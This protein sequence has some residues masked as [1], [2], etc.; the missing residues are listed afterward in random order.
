MG[1]GPQHGRAAADWA[2]C[3]AGCCCSRLVPV[4]GPRRWSGSSSSSRATASTC[5]FGFGAG[6]DRARGAV[7]SR[8]GHRSSASAR[9]VGRRRAH[10]GSPAH[11]GAASHG[12][13]PRALAGRLSK[14]RRAA[15][16]RRSHRA[17]GA[18]SARP[19]PAPRRLA[20]PPPALRARPSLR[21]AADVGS[22]IRRSPARSDRRR[23][24]VAGPLLRR[25]AAAR[26]RGR[27][28][29][30]FDR[31]RR[32]VHQ[33]CDRSVPRRRRA[34]PRGASAAADVGRRN[35]R[36]PMPAASAARR[37]CRRRRTR[38]AAA[39]RRPVTRG[40]PPAPA[41]PHPRRE[42]GRRGTRSPDGRRRRR[43]RDVRPGVGDRRRPGCRDPALRAR[44]GVRAARQAARSPRTPL[45]ADDHRPP[46]TR[47][48]WSLVPPARARRSR[49]ARDVVILGRRPVADP[50]VPRRAARLDRGRHGLQDPRATRAARRPLVHHRPRLHE[51]RAVR[52]ADGH[53]GRGR[54]P[55]S[56]SRRRAVPP[57]RRRGAAP[58]ER[59]DVT[60]L[61]RATLPTRAA[62]S[63]TRPEPTAMSTPRGSAR[64]AD[65]RSRRPMADDPH[66]STVVIR[67]A[68]IDDGGSTI[69]PAATAPR[70]RRHPARVRPAAATASHG[71]RS[72]RR[73][74][75]TPRRGA[76]DLRARARARP[77]VAVRGRAARPAP[78]PRQAP[79]STATAARS[80]A[81]PRRRRRSLIV[82]VAA[83]AIA[84]R[85]P[86]HRPRRSLAGISAEADP[87]SF[88]HPSAGR[89]SLRGVRSR[90]PSACLGT[91][92]GR[93][94][95]ISGNGLRTG[96]PHGISTTQT[97]QSFCRAGGSM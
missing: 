53:R 6:H 72:C 76:G 89:V 48:A 84:S 62:V 54:R 78:R 58:A 97:R 59:W 29:A 36:E 43:P 8:C 2:D 13:G 71:V 46:A 92:Q 65:R 37:R 20:P 5:A 83:S 39:R 24:R 64:T 77:P 51:R 95:R 73:T 82:V 47:T 7:C 93:G 35:S 27:S 70:A 66:G 40:A 74:A 63:T 30:A 42:P 67:A 19:P 23:R 44:V 34:P 55:A 60:R 45:D 10:A 15:P 87:R 68:A 50:D 18:A 32:R 38:R 9:P 28:T 22:R 31:R 16:P 57:R 21:H 52:D 88:D 41:R 33:R 91:R 81:A 12:D 17:A 49:S 11:R 80:H 4:V 1:A 75:R 96:H 61:R 26:G 90:A 85:W 25:R 69:A 86:R 94:R 14:P 79:S 3:R 56:R